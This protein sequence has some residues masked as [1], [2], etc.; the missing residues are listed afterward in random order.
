DKKRKREGAQSVAPVKRF[1]RLNE[2][3]EKRVVGRKKKSDN[4]KESDGDKM[5]IE[6]EGE[7]GNEGDGEKM[8]EVPVPPP[9]LAEEGISAKVDATPEK[10]R[11]PKL[12][13]EEKEIKR[14]E[15]EERKKERD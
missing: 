5:D 14:K 10:E 13:A 2:Q 8:E 7:E 9:I 3:G 11:K 4:P 12:S 1:V 15:K 6:G